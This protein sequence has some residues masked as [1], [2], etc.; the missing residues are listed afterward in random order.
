MNFTAWPTS[1][2]EGVDLLDS[3]C[4]QVKRRQ[5]PLPSLHLDPP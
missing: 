1:P 4:Q 2:E 3:V 5:M